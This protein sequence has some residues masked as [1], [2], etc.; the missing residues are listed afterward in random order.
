LPWHI[1]R[2]CGF[3]C[4]AFVASSI[5]QGQTGMINLPYRR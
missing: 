1:S 4:A 3:G 2:L 5:R